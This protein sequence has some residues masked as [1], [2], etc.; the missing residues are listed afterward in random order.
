M[1]K[2][3]FIFSIFLLNGCFYSFKTGCFYAPQSVNCN[4]KYKNNFDSYHKKDITNEQ[5]L[6]DMKTCLGKYGDNID[7]KKNIFY[8]LYKRY[9]NQNIVH[10][11]TLCMEHK[12]YIFNPIYK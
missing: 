2:Y 9:P 6:L 12:G 7:Y 4:F 11:F 1:K 3:I 5:K 10:E 8:D